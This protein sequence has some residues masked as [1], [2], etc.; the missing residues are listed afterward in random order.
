MEKPKWKATDDPKYDEAE[1]QWLES[2][3]KYLTENECD[4][5]CFRCQQ[6]DHCYPDECNPTYYNDPDPEYYGGPDYDLERDIERGK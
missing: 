6:D 1:R 4:C 5:D 3:R 2:A